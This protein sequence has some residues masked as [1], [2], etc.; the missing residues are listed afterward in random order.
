M[1]EEVHIY[2]KLLRESDLH[3]APCAQETLRILASWIL[4]TRYEEPQNSNI[5]SKM[6]V[7][8]GEIIKDTDPQAKSYIEYRTTAGIKEGMNGMSTRFA[9]NGLSTASPKKWTCNPPR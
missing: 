4:A 9:F 7:Y 3:H 8:N 1:D 6:K 2:E 5:W